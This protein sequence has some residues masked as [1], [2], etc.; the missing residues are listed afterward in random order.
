MSIALMTGLR[1]PRGRSIVTLPWTVRQ[2]LMAC[3]E[4][5]RAHGMQFE[6]L[7]ET[8]RAMDP[9]NPNGW[10]VRSENDNSDGSLS[11]LTCG[12][13]LRRFLALT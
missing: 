7:C 4:A 1:D 5:L 13:T 6:V 9:D 2:S 8:C 12:C 10:T 3:D 11:G